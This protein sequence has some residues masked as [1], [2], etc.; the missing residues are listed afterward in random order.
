[1]RAQK[2]ICYDYSVP[3]LKHIQEISSN[4]Y[5]DYVITSEIENLSIDF[6]LSE[7]DPDIEKEWFEHIHI[8]CPF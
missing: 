1:M 7:I 2:F 8:E 6:P 5:E 3:W 4:K